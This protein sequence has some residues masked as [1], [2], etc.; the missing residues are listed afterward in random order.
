MMAKE[1]KLLPTRHHKDSFINSFLKKV[2]KDGKMRESLI[3][4]DW[5]R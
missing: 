2:D 4:A 5:L 1:V 3:A